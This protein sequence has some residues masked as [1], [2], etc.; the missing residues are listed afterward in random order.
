M[1][2][3]CI[4]FSLIISISRSL[5]CSLTPSLL[6]SLPFFI[7][8]SVCIKNNA[9]FPNKS[10]QSYCYAV[11]PVARISNT[12]KPRLYTAHMHCAC[13]YGTH[14]HVSPAVCMCVRVCF[15]LLFFFLFSKY[16]KTS[17]GR[18]LHFELRRWVE[19]PN[20]I[21]L[22]KHSS[23]IWFSVLNIFNV[24]FRS[25]QNRKKKF[26]GTMGG[27]IAINQPYFCSLL[28]MKIAPNSTNPSSL[29]IQSWASN[30]I[31]FNHIACKAWWQ[32]NKYI[33]G[34]TG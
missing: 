6:R 30:Q 27:L 29:C 13:Q 10:T 4:Y 3:N 18:K 7:S 22:I 33:S 19:K 9:F 17:S 5:A 34:W 8:L 28:S 32:E 20:W 2:N 25:I 24:L 31:P 21:L 26:D 23:K 12:S 14:V 11:L 1:R 16:Y 15:C